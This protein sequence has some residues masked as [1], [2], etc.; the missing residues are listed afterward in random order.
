MKKL[1]YILSVIFCLIIVP[2]SLVFADDT[3]KLGTFTLAPTAPG[4][5][6]V[7]L[8]AECRLESAE[9]KIDRMGGP[10]FEAKHRGIMESEIKE[11]LRNCTDPAEGCT[12]DE[13][14]L[15]TNT[16][17]VMD[18]IHEVSKKIFGRD[19]WIYAK[20]LARYAMRQGFGLSPEG[21]QKMVESLNPNCPVDLGHYVSTPIYFYPEVGMD[22]KLSVAGSSPYAIRLN[23]SGIF[24]YQ[25]LSY[26]SVQYG[27]NS[28]KPSQPS[29]GKLIERNRL[30][31]ELAKIA[32][33]LNFTEKEQDDF[34][35]YWLSA[36]PQANYY[37]VSLLDRQ[38]AKEVAPWTVKPLPT[39]EIRYI[40][41]FKPL[42]EK[43]DDLLNESRFTPSERKGFTVV[44]I[45]GIIDW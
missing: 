44:D 11:Y 38:E 15:N 33:D 20:T 2:K 43:P 42:M 23:K 31:T 39:T 4:T 34:V 7:T 8:D 14:T 12:T 19:E 6:N 22:I 40:L 24:D 16:Q 32:E 45:G 10:D 26:S 9:Q 27:I 3:L 37:S 36:L 17:K 21:L 30:N 13:A 18:V 25:N 35:T 28:P 1:I 5:Y 29:T 41:Y